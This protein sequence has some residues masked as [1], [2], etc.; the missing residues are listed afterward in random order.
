[1]WL[2]LI[3]QNVLKFLN[4]INPYM[5]R[6]KIF[7]FQFFTETKHDTVWEVHWTVGMANSYFAGEK[8]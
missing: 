5:L 8:T 6:N 3:H 4:V 2:D 1:M 7:S